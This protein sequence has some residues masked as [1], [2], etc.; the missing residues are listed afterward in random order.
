MSSE[1]HWQ[2]KEYWRMQMEA[3]A[4]KE[5]EIRVVEEQRIEHERII[6]E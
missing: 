6:E 4:I 5:M 2:I 1:E 3:A